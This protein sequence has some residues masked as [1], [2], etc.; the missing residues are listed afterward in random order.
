[1]RSISKHWEGRRLRGHQ[2][3]IFRLSVFIINRE[4]GHDV[5]VDQRVPPPIDPNKLKRVMTILLGILL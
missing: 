4:K 1:M 2:E 3:E 5:T